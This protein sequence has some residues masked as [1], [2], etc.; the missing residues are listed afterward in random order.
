MKKLF[1]LAAAI[2]A[3]ASCS[4]EQATYVED[5]SIKFATM[6]TRT[7]VSNIND[8]EGEGNG[9]TVFGFANDVKIFDNVDATYATDGTKK[10]WE[11][12]TKRYWA[13]KTT[14]NFFAVYP[15]VESTKGFTL[16]TADE[17][18]VAKISFTNEGK[19]DLILAGT[20]VITTTGTDGAGHGPAHMNFKHA[21]S[22]VA[23]AFKNGY[24]PADGSYPIYLA[25]EGLQF[26]DEKGTGTANI[27]STVGENEQ[28]ITWETVNKSGNINFMEDN[29]TDEVTPK[30]MFSNA[31]YIV[32][33]ETA[34]TDYKYIFPAKDAEYKLA[35][36]ITAYYD[37]NG[38]KKLTE[39]DDV[40]REFDYTTTNIKLAVDKNTKFTH[41]MGKSYTY[42]MT[43]AENLNEITFTVSVEDWT[44]GGS[45]DIDFP[46]NN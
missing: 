16:A 20:Q 38:D 31:G 13:D 42:T 43:V 30:E 12:T 22:R 29:T 9:F 15:Q 11:M 1:I 45:E 26:V 2:V 5:G 44:T 23:F 4:K 19:T 32:K 8:L 34:T 46:G 39:A 28:A 21:L 36:K 18:T 7:A 10:W 24:N 33:G 14:Y 6:E 25:V 3:F 17:E 41:E 27:K 37:I 35:C 40:I